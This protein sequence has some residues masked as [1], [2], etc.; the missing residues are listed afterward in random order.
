MRRADWRRALGRAGRPRPC[1]GRRGRRRAPG[2]RPSRKYGTSRAYRATPSR[3]DADVAR[4]GARA[5][6]LAGASRPDP[7]QDHGMRVLKGGGRAVV[8]GSLEKQAFLFEERLELRPT[9]GS[10]ECLRLQ[11]GPP[12]PSLARP[13]PLAPTQRHPVPRHACPPLCRERRSR[14]TSRQGL[15]ERL[16]NAAACAARGL[17]SGVQRPP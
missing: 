16:L 13:V 9:L 5:R 15:S 8:Q 1:R 17:T 7:Q 10:E 14:G 6:L 4:H 12:R 2:P 3:P 11:V